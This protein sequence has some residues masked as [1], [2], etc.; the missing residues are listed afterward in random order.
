MKG[1]ILAGGDGSRLGMEKAFLNLHGEIQV[2]Y[3]C[4]QFRKSNIEPFVSVPEKKRDQFQEY[5]LIF[6]KSD[7][8][9]PLAGIVAAFDFHSGPWMVFAVDMPFINSEVMEY[10]LKY[11]KPGVASCLT[12]DNIN[13]EP[14]ASIWE[15]ESYPLLQTYIADGGESASGFLKANG[16]NLLIVKDPNWVKSINTIED[17]EW[18]RQ[19]ID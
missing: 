11:R 3:L 6:D 13:P 8:N 16:A 15:S 7:I 4:N 12:I 2:S 1:L 5:D 9:G 17:L 19:C 14:M 10:F 18:A